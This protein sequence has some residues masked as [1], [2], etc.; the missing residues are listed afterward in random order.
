MQLYRAA[1]RPRA[2]RARYRAGVQPSKVAPYFVLAALVHLAAV[3]TRFDLVAARV[4][5]PVA[6]GIMVAQCPLLL[7]SGYFEGRLDHGTRASGMPRWMQIDARPV[8]WAFTFG[9]I[10]FACVAAQTWHVSFGPVDPTPPAA[11]PPATRAMWFA[12][13]TVGMAFPFYLLAAGVVIPVLRAVTWPL[14][15]L[16]A[17]LGALLALVL[18]GAL[19]VALLSAVTSSQL[20]GFI[21]KLQA[22]IAGDPTI[23]VAVTLG[24]LLVPMLVGLVLE[25]ED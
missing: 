13:F 24:L 3:A 18:G 10:Y 15:Q 17:L 11:F 4:P 12:M 14:R 16:P 22:T 5:A 8:K 9:V 2:C 7:L 20:R 19:G 25:R 23:A 1:A 21:A 6:L